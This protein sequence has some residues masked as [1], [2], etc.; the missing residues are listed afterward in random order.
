MLFGFRAPAKKAGLEALAGELLEGGFSW[1]EITAEQAS[2]AE[3]LAVLERIR[4]RYAPVISVHCQFMDI[5]PCSLVPEVREAARS[6]LRK[7]LDLAAGLG[8]RVAV[9]HSGSIGWVDVVPSNH[10]YAAYTRSHA[11]HEYPRHFPLLVEAVSQLA[12]YA[13][14]RGV[15]LTVENEFYPGTMVH[16]PQQATNLLLEAL[17]GS[18]AMTLDFGHSLVSGYDPAEYVDAVGKVIVHTHIHD[19]DGVYDQ[20]LPV[21]RGILQLHP[22]LPKLAAASPDITLL[23]EVPTHSAAAMLDGRQRLLAAMKT[24]P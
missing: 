22:V 6:V 4:R 10:P 13:A 24:T 16:S 17:H 21:G 20:H 7:D 3:F 11:A 8:A 2:D 14:Q 23:L 5:N 15:R 18:V 1:I 12:A 19:N 9:M